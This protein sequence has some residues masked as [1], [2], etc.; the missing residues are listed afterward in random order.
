MGKDSGKEIHHL[1]LEFINENGAEKIIIIKIKKLMCTL[2]E[3]TDSF[4]ETEF[5]LQELWVD[6]INLR[7]TNCQVD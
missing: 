2:A 6:G 5:Q 1:P 7:G 3:S 4:Q